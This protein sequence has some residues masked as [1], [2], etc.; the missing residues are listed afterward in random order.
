MNLIHF[1][2]GNIGCG[3]I[4]P[5]LRSIVDH[6]YFVDNNIDIVNKINNQKLIKIHTSDN[7]KITITNISAWLLTDFINYKNTWNEVSLLTISIG[8]KNLKHIIYYV[9]QLIDYKIKNNQKLIIMCCENGIRVSSLFKYYFSNLN[10]NI[11]F[12]DV[13]V[14]R[15][16]SNKNIL[17]DYLECEDYYLWVVDK[18]QWPNDFKQI[19]GLTYTTSFDIQIAKKIYM[20]NALHC[21]IAWFVFKNFDLNKYLY[22]YQ[23]LKNDKVIEFVN[24][25]LNE[26]ILVLNHKYNINLNELNDYKIQ[27]IKRLN[28]SF[29]KDDL[30]RLARNTELKL[31]K[32]ERIL[33]IL[34][35]A[36]DNN[37]KHDT[38]L[39]SYQNGLE[40][41]KKIINRIEKT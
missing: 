25:Y 14:D 17:N 41:L 11:Y 33:T 34:D 37:L 18:T 27:I 22:V 38:L 2:A 4:A 9:S 19:P 7:K 1:G 28:N 6:I 29:I 35:Y 8:I 23:A 26:V 32:N 10:N 12:V 5:I 30:K 21:S 31:S 15:I 16:V 36:K 13:L 20:L 40:Y 39:L 24:N 3:F